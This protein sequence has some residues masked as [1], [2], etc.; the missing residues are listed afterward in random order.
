MSLLAA[1]IGTLVKK[2]AICLPYEN[3][4]YFF[5]L[6]SKESFKSIPEETKYKIPE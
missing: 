5:F 6:I 1:I 2:I 4:H 3:Y